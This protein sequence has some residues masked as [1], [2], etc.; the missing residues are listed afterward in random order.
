M[1]APKIF[2][3]GN[4]SKTK[5]LGDSYAKNLNLGVTRRILQVLKEQSPIK[6][7]NLAMYSRMNHIVCKRYLESMNVLGWI[8]LLSHSK[9]ILI[10]L[11]DSGI[12][13]QTMLDSLVH[14]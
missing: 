13:I 4:K 12:K 10:K 5:D 9:N 3:I 8:E 2:K 14:I 6:I 1:V 11:T 7:T